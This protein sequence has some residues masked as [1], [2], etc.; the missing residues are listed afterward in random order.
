MFN[1]QGQTP[2]RKK[3]VL[4]AVG[5]GIAAYKVCE[6]VSRLFKTGVEVRVILTQAAQQFITPLTLATLSRHCAY[7]DDDF[8]QASHLRPLHIELG[9]WADLLVIAPLTAHTLAKLACGLAD[10]L[11][12]NTVLASSCPVLLAPAMNTDMWAQVAVGRNWQQ[13]LTDTRYHGMGVGSGLLACD[14]I[15]AGRMAEPGEILTYI[16]SL[17]H[18]GGKRDLAG[19]NVLISAGGTREYIDPVRF[20]GNPSTGKMGLALAQAAMHR[21]AKVTLVHSPA[22]WEVPLGVEAIPVVSAES[23]GAA[24]KSHLQDANIIIMSAAVADVKPKDYSTQKLPKRSLPSSLPLEPVPDIIAQLAQLKQPSQVLVGFA[25]Q[26]GDIITP[27]RAKLESKNL[28]V[29]VANPIDQPESGFGSDNNQAVF[30]DKQGNQT[31]VL[32]GSKLQVA[33][34]LFDFLGLFHSEPSRGGE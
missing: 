12:T 6:L 15:G 30:L 8:W 19:E 28:D 1:L 13:L 16:Q 29:I 18:T 9:E 32:L 5:G 24:M 25:A 10:N 2:N 27:A 14:R 11:L 31:E 20:I 4:I 26:T 7:T 22:S 3:R 23:M 34:C 33:H 21:G 17:L